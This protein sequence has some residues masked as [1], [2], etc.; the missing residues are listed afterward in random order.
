[1]KLNK[2]EPA[3]QTQNA[4]TGELTW[5][6]RIR[7]GQKQRFI[8]EYEVDAPYDKPVGGV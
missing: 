4:D 7:S 6:S 5:T 2:V 8:V 1:V 3:L